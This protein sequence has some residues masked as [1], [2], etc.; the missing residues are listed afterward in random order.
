MQSKTTHNNI[1]KTLLAS[2]SSY[3][4]KNYTIE[5]DTSE[6]YS[7]ENYSI[8]KT[9]KK[10]SQKLFNLEMKD[11]NFSKP[12]C[13]VKRNM[14]VSG[15]ICLEVTQDISLENI[16]GNLDE[17]FSQTLLK[18]ISSSHKTDVDVYK[19]ANIDRKH[20]SKIRSNPSYT[21]S[22]KTVLALAFA[23]EL[24][25]LQTEDL[26]KR[27]GFSLSHSYKFDVIM[28]YFLINKIYNIFEINE[29][30]FHY[31]QQLLGGEF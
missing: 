17:S 6:S 18:L 16:V 27:A 9:Q 15:S 3:I 2:I 14:N 20:F 5:S 8:R 7:A 21:P 1:S 31:D 28:E 19:K 11:L 22:K 26:L 10:P 25:L 23:L 30:L 12:K 13:L 4:E 29:V 24:S